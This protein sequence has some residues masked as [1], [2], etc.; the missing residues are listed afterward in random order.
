MRN[1]FKISFSSLTIFFVVHILSFAQGTNILIDQFGYPVKSKKIAVLREPKTGFDSGKSY[2]PGNTIQIVDSKTNQVISTYSPVLWNNGLTH[3]QSGDKV[4]HVDFSKVEL[5]GS[6]FLYDVQNNIKS[7]TF[8]I[9]ND[10]YFPVLKAAFKTMYYQRAGFKK[11]EEFAGFWSDEASH[12]GALQDK[13]A[14]LYNQRNNVATEKDLSGGWFDAGDYNKYTPW[15]ADYVITM[16]NTY[17]ENKDVW[18]DDFGIPESGNGIPDL[19]DE[20]KWGMDWLLKM[21]Q[22]DGSS[23]SVLGIS[24]ASPPS[25]ARGQSLYGPATTNATLRSSAA[26]ALGALVFSEFTSHDALVQY[27]KLLQTKAELA[28]TWADNNRNVT[29]DN[30]SSTNGSQ[31]VGAGNQETNDLGRLTAKMRASLYLYRLTNKKDY[32]TFFENNINQLPLLAWSNYVSQ[33]FQEQQEILLD[34]TLLSDAKQD[35]IS[36]I[37]SAT[38]IAGHNNGDFIDALGKTIDPYLAFIK[39]YNWGSNR[40]KAVYGNYFY[41]YLQYKL[42]SPHRAKIID[43]PLDYLHYIH[44]VNPFNIVYLS[45]MYPYQA[46]NSVNEFYHSWFNKGNMLYGRVGSSLYGPAPGFLVGG[47][48]QFYSVDGCC[49]NNCG[50]AANNA[51]CNTADLRPP[52]NQPPMKSYKDFNDSWP[53]NSWQVTENSNGYQLEYI[54]LLSKFIAKEQTTSNKNVEI[55]HIQIYPNP[56]QDHLTIDFKSDEKV[57]NCDIYTTDGKHVKKITIFQGKNSI[58]VSNLITGVYILKITNDL[59]T[60]SFKFIKK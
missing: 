27:S 3:D 41:S 35:I 33:Y 42:E 44:G 24:H 22:N 4:W 39:D 48:N 6:Y 25:S 52:L 46:E 21:S 47:P 11:T 7:Y 45:N 36:R 34:Y 53:K 37:R 40:Y 5:P 31:G 32:L 60:K 14:R 43:A 58:N 10:V 26:F 55:D 17:L 50:S 30:N 38:Q 56:T 28:W 15:S 59:Q 13:N 9:A 49:P 51:Q 20:V 8:Q 23:L 1:N 16:L 54:R 18:T 29:F 19:I 2:A 12:I 57:Y